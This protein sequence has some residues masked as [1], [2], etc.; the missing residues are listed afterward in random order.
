[1]DFLGR[2]MV[3]ISLQFRGLGLYQLVGHL[4]YTILA[5]F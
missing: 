4:K 3:A 5:S 2:G 1:M